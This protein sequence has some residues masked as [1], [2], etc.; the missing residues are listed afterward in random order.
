MDLGNEIAEQGGGHPLFPR[1]EHETGPDKRRIELIH[2]ERLKEDNTWETCPRVFRAMEL[3]SWHDVVE[4]FGGGTYRAR[5]QSAKNYQ[6]QGSSERKE[7]S[8]IPS[9]PFVEEP[10][11]A[12]NLNAAPQ[13]INAAPLPQVAPIAANVGNGGAP[14][15]SWNVFGANGQEGPIWLAMMLKMMDRPAPP[16]PPPPDNSVLVAMINANAMRDK[17]SMEQSA[18]LMRAMMDRPAPP[19][20][21]PTVGPLEMIR[22]LTPILQSNTGPSQ[23]REGIEIAKTLMQ[24]NGPSAPAQQEDF[25]ST[26][27]TIMRTLSP[28]TIPGF[29]P[30]LPAAPEPPRQPMPAPPPGPPSNAS[31]TVPMLNMADLAPMIAK[32]RNLVLQI[33]AELRKQLP[34][35]DNA[36]RPDAT[37]TQSAAKASPANTESHSPVGGNA[38]NELATKST[39][40]NNESQTTISGNAN[41]ELAAKAPLASTESH[42]PVGDRKNNELAAKTSVASTHSHELVGSNANTELSAKPTV[43]NTESQSP[44]GD[45]TNT[46]LAALATLPEQASFGASRHATSDQVRHRETGAR[47]VPAPALQHTSGS[48]LPA[49]IA[50]AREFPIDLSFLQSEEVQQLIKSVGEDGCRRIVGMFAG[51]APLI[52][53]PPSQ[54]PPTVTATVEISKKGGAQ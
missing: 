51:S 4:R 18:M 15:Q 43:A 34:A 35:N 13:P 47:F 53:F 29:P 33:M 8:G 12:A 27:A 1:A 10:K 6:W 20:P 54:E 21:P 36:P 23:L 41:T 39:I 7:F 37:N 17:A 25:A 48:P 38:N 30:S 26:F 28:T 3:R 49:E 46:E 50:N 14:P 5:A 45:R 52:D 40:A 2:I 31:P 19:Q 42:S 32:D 11:R 24:Q 9:K 44:A 16:P 22:E